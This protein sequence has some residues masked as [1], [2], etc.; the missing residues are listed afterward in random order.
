[1]PSASDIP[2]GQVLARQRSSPRASDPEAQKEAGTLTQA[3]EGRPNLFPTR[4]AVEHVLS[5]LLAELRRR[6]DRL[7]DVKQVSDRT[8][9]SRNTIWVLERAGRFPRPS[10]P[11]WARDVDPHAIVGICHGLREGSRAW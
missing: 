1:M 9:L 11:L 6:G 7:L 10:P 8:T 2:R 5:D 4:A 3:A